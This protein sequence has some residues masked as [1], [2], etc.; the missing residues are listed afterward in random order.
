[1]RKFREELLKKASKIFDLWQFYIQQIRS[2]LNPY[3]KQDLSGFR[4]TLSIPIIKKHMVYMRGFSPCLLA[5]WVAMIMI[6]VTPDAVAQPR[7]TKSQAYGDWL[8]QC[9]KVETGT[10]G[11]EERCGL[12]Q[13]V[14]T[15]KVKL[16]ASLSV[17]R[18]G[19]ERKTSLL[20]LTLPLGVSLARGVVMDI[21]GDKHFG[22]M[23]WVT[24]V[25]G[26]CL[27]EKVLEP[28]LVKALRGGRSL[29]ATARTLTKK[30]DLI[31]KFSLHG[32]AGGE[33]QVR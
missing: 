30:S 27:A 5:C 31:M 13:G 28:S 18:G 7:F 19:S 26:G 14:G 12:T 6:V 21:D 16:V 20:R 3:A 4:A 29:T 8:L 23:A 10:G 1:M 25:N 9:F 32:F 22:K 2:V 33:K 11:T 15:K 24:C 17:I